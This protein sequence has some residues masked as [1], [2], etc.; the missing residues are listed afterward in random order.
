MAHYSTA[1]ISIPKVTRVKD[2]CSLPYNG[3]MLFLSFNH[4]KRKQTSCFFLF[5]VKNKLFLFRRT[6][7]LGTEFNMQ[8]AYFNIS[9]SF[10]RFLNRFFVSPLFI[11]IL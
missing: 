1:E 8:N 7:P 9:L 4:T 11:Y 3:A 10:V 2:K 5:L 6:S